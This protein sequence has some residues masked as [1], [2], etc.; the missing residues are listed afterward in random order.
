MLLH[1]VKYTLYLSDKPAGTYSDMKYNILKLRH[2]VGE[3]VCFERGGFFV[4]LLV[5]QQLH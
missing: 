2:T 5:L 4:G 3:T 1:S